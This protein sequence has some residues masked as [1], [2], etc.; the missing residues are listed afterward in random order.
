MSDKESDSQY[1]EDEEG[2]KITPEGTVPKEEEHHEEPQQEAPPVE[3]EHHEPEPEPQPETPQEV[4]A[5]EEEHHEE[6]KACACPFG[7]KCPFENPEALEKIIEDHLV[8]FQ[9]IQEVL[10]FKRPIVLAI[11]FVFLNLVFF[12]Y[13]KL[14]L[15]FY[16]LVTLIAILVTLYKAFL[17]AQVPKIVSSLF[18]TNVDQGDANSPTRIRNPKEISQ[19]FEKYLSW[20]PVVI[21]TIRKL[22]S[23]QT[24]TG[25]LI[26]AGVLFCLFI[27]FVAIDLFWPIVILS[28]VL[29]LALPIYCVVITQ[30]QK[31]K[32]N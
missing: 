26:W 24:T 16:A 22:R 13:R 14:D 8:C 32:A 2:N 5:Q 3:E 4:P 10:L 25:R 15:N 23:D 30:M 17:A 20:M 7:G 9:R 28:N 29:L 31:P 6:C 27:I 11:A 18:G 1:S 19:L 12:L 21:R